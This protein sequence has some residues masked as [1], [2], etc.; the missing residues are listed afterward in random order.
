MRGLLK[1]LASPLGL[2]PPGK[3]C[4]TVFR[5]KNGRE[6]EA[7]SLLWALAQPRCWRTWA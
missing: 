1:W 7:E 6:D 4:Q 3:K 2:A 5:C